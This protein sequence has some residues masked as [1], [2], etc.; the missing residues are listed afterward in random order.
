MRI[1]NVSPEPFFVSK[2]G[3]TDEQRW[4][5]GTSKFWPVNEV[6][7]TCLLVEIYNPWFEPVVKYHIINEAKNSKK[8]SL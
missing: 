7:S 8:T 5:M 3:K 6:P 1:E 2:W 4:K